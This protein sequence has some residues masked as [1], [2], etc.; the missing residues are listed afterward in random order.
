MASHQH[1]YAGL[2]AGL[3]TLRYR[4]CREHLQRFVISLFGTGDGYLNRGEVEQLLLFQL[5]RPATSSEL[6]QYFCELDLNEDGR[7]SL[8]EY[9]TSITGGT[10]H[11]RP[12]FLPRTGP[13]NLAVPVPSWGMTIK[14]WS[15][16]VMACSMTS[17]WRGVE[18]RAYKKM[19]YGDY[20]HS[21]EAN[22][23]W[24]ETYYIVQEQMLLLRNGDI[25]WEEFVE[26]MES[27]P[28]A[29]L[30]NGVE[31]ELVTQAAE[32][33]AGAAVVSYSSANCGRVQAHEDQFIP[34]RGIHFLP[35]TLVIRP[36][37]A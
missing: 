1:P 33:V 6:D 22:K 3:R 12:Q 19:A 20:E 23:V 25:S 4:R 32:L 14:Q 10:R 17:E 16:F 9:V 7:V 2:R 21:K 8:E 28:E 5:Q 11:E 15:A 30:R 37:A 29:I 18:T 35:H 36:L 27:P 24:A 13:G 31:A 34:Q 26:R